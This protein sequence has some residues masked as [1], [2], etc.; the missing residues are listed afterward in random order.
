MRTLNQSSNDSGIPIPSE[1]RTLWRGVDIGGD[2]DARRSKRG[3]AC[4]HDR[5]TPRKR[6]A[7]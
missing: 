6:A 1:N 7:Y 5:F 4:H 3:I 2:Q